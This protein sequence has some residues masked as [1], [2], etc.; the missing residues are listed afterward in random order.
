MKKGTFFTVLCF[1]IWFN[2]FGQKER[3]IYQPRLIQCSIRTGLVNG[4]VNLE[5]RLTPKSIVS[6]DF[7][8]GI[9]HLHSNYYNKYNENYSEYNNYFEDAL[10]FW[11]EWW[12]PYTSVQAKRIISSRRSIKYKSSP[13]ANTFNY[14]GLQL[15]YNGHGWRDWMDND[16]R[17]PFRET[18]QFA[19][20]L[21]G[22]WN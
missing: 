1:L 10:N 15:K 20:F 14:Y 13:Y 18:Y 4:S 12:A 9:V 6:V 7:G 2:S 11:R 5:Y 17:F 8:I 16:P 19:A 3:F 22:K 21:E